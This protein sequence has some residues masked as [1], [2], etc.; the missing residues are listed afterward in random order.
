MKH[1][2][3]RFRIFIKVGTVK[4]GDKERPD[5]EQPGNSEPFTVTNL[6][7]YFINSEQPGVS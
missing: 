2:N 6:P 4:L 1:D 7:V 5:S 3:L